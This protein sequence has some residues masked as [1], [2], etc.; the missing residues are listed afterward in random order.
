MAKHLECSIQL[1]SIL[2]GLRFNTQDGIC[3]MDVWS[4]LKAY[5]LDL[6]F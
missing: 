5:H 1:Q 4:T 3:L 2:M 6:G